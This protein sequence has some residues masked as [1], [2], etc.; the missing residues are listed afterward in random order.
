MDFT[1]DDHVVKDDS[2][3]LDKLKQAPE[4]REDEVR[5]PRALHLLVSVDPAPVAS[6]AIA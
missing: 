3:N 4:Q 2:P 1:V 5:R 6:W